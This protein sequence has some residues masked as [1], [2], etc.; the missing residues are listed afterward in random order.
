MGTPGGHMSTD[1]R[2]APPQCPEIRRAG[3]GGRTTCLF[4]RDHKGL[5]FDGG[6]Y[7]GDREMLEEEHKL[8][9]AMPA[10]LVQDEPVDQPVILNG[11]GDPVGGPWTTH[12]HAIPGVTV[13]GLNRPRRIARCGGRL[14]CTLCA[15]EAARAQAAQ[16]EAAAKK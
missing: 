1:P 3:A 11:A 9:I 12:G 7:W 4:V 14:L 8:W 13:E 15:R 2:L 10:T 16:A 6:Y 5:H